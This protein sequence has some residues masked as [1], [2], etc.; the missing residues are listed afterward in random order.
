MPLMAQINRQWRRI[1][2]R[3]LQPLGLTEA[4]WLP[5]LHLAR[6]SQPMRQK[7]LAASLS[8][9]SSSVVRLLDGLESG[10]L[11]E[12]SEGADRRA[13]TIHLTALGKTTVK[14]VE[15][16]VREGRDGVFACVPEREL[17]DAFHVLER[18]AQSLASIE[19]DASSMK[20]YADDLQGR[21]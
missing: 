18:L 8:L 11:V 5:L 4:M 14:H 9:D 15:E 12:R 13:K 19:Q 1:V 17:E 21:E 10:K 16:L 7:D 3:K 20:P 6:S 2:D